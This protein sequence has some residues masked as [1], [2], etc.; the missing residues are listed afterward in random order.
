MTRFNARGALLA[1][2]EG[3][4]LE[5]SAKT[6]AVTISGEF[7]Y[8]FNRRIRGPSHRT[9]AALNSMP[10]PYLSGIISAMPR[11]EENPFRLKASVA[12]ADL[13]S[14]TLGL[15]GVLEVQ[16]TEAHVSVTTGPPDW[17]VGPMLA[18]YVPGNISYEGSVAIG[19]SASY[20]LH[21]PG[22]G[23][24][25]RSQLSVRNSLG[26]VIS[27]E[28][29]LNAELRLRII[30]HAGTI[31]EGEYSFEAS[32]MEELILNAGIG[33]A[34]LFPESRA[35]LTDWGP[36]LGARLFIARRSELLISARY[37]MFAFNR[38]TNSLCARLGFAYLF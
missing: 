28:T 19:R 18:A 8:Y 26:I 2:A 6:Q 12:G 11:T 32:P 21:F 34:I 30:D 16:Y 10:S 24:A 9:E 20:A 25:L 37:T 22:S 14:P 36:G 31:A 3:T 4:Y 38:R 15:G 29:A 7:E 35:P 27:N 33:H 5:S 23:N 13:I 1:G 17:T